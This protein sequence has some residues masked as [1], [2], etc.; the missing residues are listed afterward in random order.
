MEEKLH[1]Y[2]KE[3]K[4]K[5][6]SVAIKQCIEEAT[7]KETTK[8]FIIELDKKLNRILYRQNLNRKILEQLFTNMDF[9]TNM[10]VET[11]LLLKKIYDDNNDRF[12]GGFG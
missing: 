2:M 9:G 3:N 5:K 8:S 6:R 7:S 10:D 11:D 4:I 1:C 12:T